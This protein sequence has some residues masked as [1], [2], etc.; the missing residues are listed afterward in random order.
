MSAAALPATP[1][2][3]RPLALPR[4][5]A[6]QALL[7]LVAA[8]VTRGALFGNPLIYGDE[9][10]YL[11]VGDR[12]VQGMWPF[13]DIFDRKP[14][15]LFLIFAAIRSV[16][17]DGIL[18][19]QL[20][21]TLCAAATAFVATRIARRFCSPGA[22]FAGGLLY[23]VWLVVFDGGG[24]QASVWYALP[25]AGA[26][27][28]A[29]DGIRERRRLSRRG[30]AAMLLVGIAMQIKYTAMFEGVFFALALLRAGW[31][32][33][34]PLPRLARD[35]VL[36]IALALLPTATALAV[37]VAAGHGEAFVFA[38]FV[39]IF[40][41]GDPD[42]AATNAVKLAQA[43]AL[44]SP[45][46]WLATRGGWRAWP[47]LEWTAIALIAVLMMGTAEQ[48]YFIPVML[49]LSI[50]AAAGLD[51]RRGGMAWRRGIAILTIGLALATLVTTLRIRQ[52]GTPA[53]AM[54]LAR[55]IGDRPAG[56]LFGFNSE[57]ILYYLTRS[58]L[59]TRYVFRSH[60]GQTSE[61]HGIDAD[62]VAESARILAHDPGVI[63][64]RTPKPTT[65]PA[66]QGLVLRAVAD[67]Y[68]PV[69]TV[70]IGRLRQYVFRL[71]RDR[72]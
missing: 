50:A 19:Y 45:L 61:A 43:A 2:H 17:G 16:G 35:A 29:I 4:S 26:G 28:L 46:V 57:P 70:R 10:F 55:M 22:A 63:V 64:I 53:Q 7:L 3:R 32:A 21:A 52:R 6:T 49:P 54:T 62:P 1:R 71:R 59:P 69:G 12:M 51:D 20:A 24:G 8:L 23:L 66:T 58:C 38:N 11:L 14:V 39:S 60:L 65:N 15:G 37:Y 34:R 41:Q 44:A 36:W 48:H 18:L 68:E 27:L 9:G 5:A 13:V 40:G 25:M 33:G 72:R 47:A 31:L 42:T 67:R 56:C 30:A